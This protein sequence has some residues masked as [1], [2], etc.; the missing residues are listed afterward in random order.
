MIWASSVVAAWAFCSICALLSFLRCAIIN[1]ACQPENP[2]S[3][4]VSSPGCWLCMM[5]V[6]M[7]VRMT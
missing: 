4:S 1:Y 2:G 5:I 3:D 6:R 7:I